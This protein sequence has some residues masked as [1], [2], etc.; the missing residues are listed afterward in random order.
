MVQSFAPLAERCKQRLQFDLAK[1]SCGFSEI[2]YGAFEHGSHADAV[3]CRIVME[4]YS[5]LHHSLKKLLIF[6]RC[7]APDV[8][9]LFV[10]CKKLS[11]VEQADAVAILF[12]IHALFWH[13]LLARVS[14]T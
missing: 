11:V 7:R 8:F 2:L 9:K 5:N 1:T 3:P 12:E 10:G 6:W 13:M 4:G 14:E